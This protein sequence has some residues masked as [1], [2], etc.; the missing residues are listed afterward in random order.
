MEHTDLT[1]ESLGRPK[2]ESECAGQHL[3]GSRVRQM[4]RERIWW[5]PRTAYCCQLVIEEGNGSGK[6]SVLHRTLPSVPSC[7]LEMKET[8]LLLKMLVPPAA[9]QKQN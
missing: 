8:T 3:P 7:D 5:R 1:W 9:E 2:V 6:A 4:V